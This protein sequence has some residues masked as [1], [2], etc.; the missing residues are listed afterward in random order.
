M[1]RP[2]SR[3][4]TSG[5]RTSRLAIWLATTQRLAGLA[6]ASA[7][8]KADRKPLFEYDDHYVMLNDHGRNDFYRRALARVIPGCG[9]DCSVLDLGAGSGLLSMMAAGLGAPNVLAIEAN[10]DLADLATKTVAW[11]KPKNYPNSNITVVA[12]LSSAVAPEEMPLGRPAD[13]LVTETFGT[14]LLGEG[15]INFVPDG[16]DRLLKKGGIMIP[17]GGCQYVTLV[18]VPD[19]AAALM[20]RSYQGLNLS[21]FE[22]LQ[23]TV[24]WKASVGAASLD[25][26]PVTERLCV[27][28]IDLY[29]DTKD[30][31]PQNRTFRVQATRTGVVHA[32]L[33][34]WD[35]WADHSRAD[36]L[37]TAPGS[38]NF[39]GDVAWGWQFQLQEGGIGEDWK[40][41]AG[42]LPTRL[43]VEA[44]DW[45]DIGVEFIA[46]GISSHVRSRRAPLQKE[47]SN[48]AS[49]TRE[50]GLLPADASGSPVRTRFANRGALRE[51]NDLYL[52]MLGDHE[53]HKFYEDAID[54]AVAELGGA[55][56]SGKYSP[57]S[58]PTL[59]DCSGGGLSALRAS[60]KYGIASLALFRWKEHSLALR[61]A[62]EDNGVEELVE[63]YASDP[64]DFIDTLLPRSEKVD[65]VVL[66]PPGTPLF[67]VSPFGVLPGIRKR[68]LKDS[69]IVVP[70]AACFE[71]GLVESNDA[72]TLFSVPESRWEDIDLTVWNKETLQQRVLEKLVPYT[73][74]FGPKSTVKWKW[75]TRPQCVFT[76]NLN[77]Y[78]RPGAPSPPNITDTVF[79]LQVEHDGHGSVLLGQWVAWGTPKD[80]ERGLPRLDG[81]GDSLSRSWTWPRFVQAVASKESP[82]R[83]GVVDPVRVVAGEAWALE[84]KVRQGAGKL[85]GAAGPEFT[86]RLRGTATDVLDTTRTSAESTGA[87]KAEL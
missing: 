76:V 58:G 27:L 14:M 40:W 6:T 75:L 64:R 66:E 37:S 4:W 24:Y 2:Q 28:E 59:L 32:A 45:I 42:D 43:H 48:A 21:R 74:W 34:D 13:V 55:S 79:D 52:P 71:V 82:R 67:G 84:V 10:P 77:E 25:V 47:P 38:R 18:E 15:A 65:I 78:G 68:L 39:A 16:R 73:K 26:Q 29:K 3:A 61:K 49:G 35:V 57:G 19:L 41:S 85:T 33:L 9:K 69:G 1:E 72:A 46:G 7:A 11:N 53:R 63:A 81:S 56:A 86:L 87:E 62:I 5:R 83:E 60:Q 30:S 12:K 36:L 8:K 23:D 80:A 50:L 51:A 70:A 44:G 22:A 17:A 31:L 20:P 54:A